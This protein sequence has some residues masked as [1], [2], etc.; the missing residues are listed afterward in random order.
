[1]AGSTA[2]R[3]RTFG[4]IAELY[5]RVRPGYPAEAVD[6]FLPADAAG[7]GELR[8]AD[9]GTCTGKLSDAL[10]AS[11]REITAVDP[12]PRMLAVR[13]AKHPEV[14]TVTGAAEQL[15]FD[16][17]S[18]DAPASPGSGS[19]PASSATRAPTS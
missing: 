13:S 4:S 7:S 1:M 8:I 12:D 16:D 2:A 10:L 11:G 6:W 18:F 19:S 15:P 14:T 17:A 5:E 9:V 3:S